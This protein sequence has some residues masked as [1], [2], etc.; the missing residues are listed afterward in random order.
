MRR[1]PSRHA[2]QPPPQVHETQYLIESG[3]GAT[4]CLF[5]EPECIQFDFPPCEKVLLI[6]RSANPLSYIEMSHAVDCLTI[7]RPGDTEVWATSGDGP[8]EQVAGFSDHPFPWIDS[9]HQAEGRPPWDWPPA[10]PTSH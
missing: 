4:F 1:R 3:D 7:W 2:A 10:P 9:G 6:F 5:I 8:A